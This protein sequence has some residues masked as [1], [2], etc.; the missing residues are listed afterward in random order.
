MTELLLE[1]VERHP[2]LGEGHSGCVAVVVDGIA[3]DASYLS[4][5]IVLRL[6]RSTREPKELVSSFETSALHLGLATT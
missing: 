4:G 6:Y 1:E 3:V 2:A 5:A